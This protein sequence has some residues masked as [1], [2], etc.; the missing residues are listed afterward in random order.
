MNAI[1]DEFASTCLGDPEKSTVV[2]EIDEL[3]RVKLKIAAVEYWL[4]I[5]GNVGT[6]SSSVAASTDLG[7]LIQRYKCDDRPYLLQLFGELQGE[8][9]ALLRILS[10][11]KGTCRTHDLLS[12]L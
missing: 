5:S 9:T 4:D 8:K 7:Q 12:K 2:E 11:K 3:R 10:M 6:V 1:T